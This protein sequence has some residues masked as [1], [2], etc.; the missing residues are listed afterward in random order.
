MI[1]D[2]GIA[3]CLVAICCLTLALW[4]ERLMRKDPS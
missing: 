2:V 1:A 4:D 3:V